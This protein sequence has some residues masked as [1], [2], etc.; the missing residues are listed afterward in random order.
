MKKNHGVLFGLAVIAIAAITLFAGCSNGSTDDAPTA[1][2]L[3]AGS[4]GT[5]GDKKI[6]VAVAGSYVV[7]TGDVWYKIVDSEGTLT[8]DPAD[9]VN[10]AAAATAE[11]DANAEITGLTNGVTY[12]V[13]LYKTS[14]SAII[15]DAAYTGGKNTIIAETGDNG[16]TVQ[17]G[18]ADGNTIIFILDSAIVSGGT[19]ATNGNAPGTGAIKTAKLWTF[20]DAE[21]DGGVKVYFTADV[22]EAFCILKGGNGY[23]TYVLT[24]SSPG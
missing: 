2:V 14:G 18:A 7:K 24:R 3:A 16:V 13:Y 9:D 4:Q 8:L 10:A 1:V 15:A 5:A 6:T 21:T 17:A 19:T 12:D 20:S 22:E 11:L 23:T